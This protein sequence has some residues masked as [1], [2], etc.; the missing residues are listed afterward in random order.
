M[1]EILVRWAPLFNLFTLF[2]LCIAVIWVLF[3]VMRLIKYLYQWVETLDKR[4]KELDVALVDIK[5][6]LQNLDQEK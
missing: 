4:V 6:E 2:I 3:R 1:K 5:W